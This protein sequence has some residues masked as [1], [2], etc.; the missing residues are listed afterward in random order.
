MLFS[1]N[2]VYRLTFFKCRLC[3][4]SLLPVFGIRVSVKFLLTC[5]HDILVRFELLSGHHLRNSC[6][7]G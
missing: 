6:S 5:V 4:G 7:L 1:V 3:S 2:G